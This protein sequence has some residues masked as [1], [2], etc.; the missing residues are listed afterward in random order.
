MLTNGETFSYDKNEIESYVVTG[1]KYVPVKVK[2]EDYEAFKAAYTV[3][4]NGST[5]S[6]GFSEGNLKNYTDLVAEVTENTNGLKTVTQNEDGSF[7]FAA[8]VNNG[9]DSG[10]KDAALKT[11]ENIT[12]TVKE[13]NG[14][15]GEFLRVDL[16]GEGYGALGAD[17]QAGLIMDPTVLIPI[18]FN[19]MEPSLHQITGCTKH[20]ESSLVLQIHCVVNCRREQTE[21]DTG[22]SRYMH[23]VTMITR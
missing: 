19:L 21:P 16:T 9:T 23:L 13:A 12:T 15:Y 17:M 3:V 10:I 22:Q 4:E 6:G 1:L 11:A 18:H 7:S 5:L 2:T 8:R 14:S 20:R